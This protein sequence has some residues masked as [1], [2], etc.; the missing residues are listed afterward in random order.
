V[1]YTRYVD[2][3]VFSRGIP[4]PFFM[5]QEIR[6]FITEAGFAVNHRKSTVRSRQ[7]GTVFVTKIGMREDSAESGEA[8]P[9][10]L[11]FPQKKR[12]RIHGIIQSYLTKELWNESPEVIRGIIAEFLHYYK[13]VVIPT[14]TDAKTFALCKEFERVSE[15]YR[16]DYTKKKKR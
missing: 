6:R 4:I 14:K 16:K 12:R 1:T 15:P 5:R 3:L 11:V 13:Q 9:A 8:K 2:D 7:M 10:I